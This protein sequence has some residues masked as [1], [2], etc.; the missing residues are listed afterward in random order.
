MIALFA[1]DQV[2]AVNNKDSLRRTI[3][4][5]HVEFA[6]LEP[7]KRKV[8]TDK[9]QIQIMNSFNFVGCTL[10]FKEENEVCNKIRKCNVNGTTYTTFNI[11]CKQIR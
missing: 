1:D 5:L 11:K 9:H 3:H 10:L 7:T 8:V 2:I 4:E 6:V